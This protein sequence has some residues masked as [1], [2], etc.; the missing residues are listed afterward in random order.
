MVRGRNGG[1]RS[2]GGQSLNDPGAV[3]REDCPSVME[4]VIRLAVGLTIIVDISL[5]NI[6]QITAIASVFA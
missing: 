1:R 5:T 4:V 6:H 2:P 3:G